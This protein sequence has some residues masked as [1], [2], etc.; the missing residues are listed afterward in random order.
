MVESGC[1]R[2]AVKE[3]LFLQDWSKK[4]PHTGKGE[5]RRAELREKGC[6]RVSASTASRQ[7]DDRAAAHGVGMSLAKGKINNKI[8]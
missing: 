7:R 8:C 3:T 1:G 4:H 5:R 6:R 2:A